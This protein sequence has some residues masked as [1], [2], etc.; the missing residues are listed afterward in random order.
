MNLSVSLWGAIATVGALVVI[1][2]G[3]ELGAGGSGG[4]GASGGDGSGGDAMSMGG[5]GGADACAALATS[6]QTALDTG[7]D[8]A[9]A[10]GAVMTVITP[11]CGAWDGV[12]AKANVD[13]PKS[14]QLLRIGSITKTY[15]AA[16]VLLLVSDGKIA[17]DEKAA[18]YTTALDPTSPV[19]V[20]QLLNH[21]SGIFNYTND[22]AFIEGALDAPERVYAPTELVEVALAHPPTNA[23]GEAWNYSNTNFVLLGLIAESV[24]QAPLATQIRTRLLEPLGLTSTFLDGDEIATIP[25]NPGFSASGVDA[26]YAA[27]P[28]FAWAAGAMLA[29]TGDVARWNE[30]LIEGKVVMEPELAAM[31]DGVPTA[32]N[33][34]TYGL[35]VMILSADI[36]IEKGI[37]H[38]GDIFGYHCQSVY[39]PEKETAVSA[40]V[41]SDH[42]VN[43][44]LA[45]TLLTLFVP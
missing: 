17:L 16:T 29:T 25:L 35:G 6:L 43:D 22:M 2:C 11:A 28:S 13:P 37:G 24:G 42:S 21:T 45:E 41:T 12:S 30:A 36:A 8:A 34:L 23:P 1:G 38:G 4:T 27:D 32:Q 9:R 18:T 40:C 14:Q 19:T 44:I 39:F 15:V 31:L 3:D 20:R 26:T 7:R 5:S 33:G 10:R